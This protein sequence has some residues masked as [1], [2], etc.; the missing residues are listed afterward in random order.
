MTYTIAPISLDSD[1]VAALAQHLG[2][3]LV[4]LNELLLLDDEK[5]LVNDRLQEH[6]ALIEF[7]GFEMDS[8]KTSIVL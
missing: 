2:A 4:N 8:E 6:I 1:Q 5:E 7:L 3:M